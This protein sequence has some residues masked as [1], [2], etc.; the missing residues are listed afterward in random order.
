M[1]EDEEDVNSVGSEGIR[2]RATQILDT[3]N[4]RLVKVGHSQFQIRLNIFFTFV[5]ASTVEAEPYDYL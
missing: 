2:E 4:A 1:S 5:E 3:Y